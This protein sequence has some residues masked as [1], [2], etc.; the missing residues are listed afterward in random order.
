MGLPPLFPFHLAEV[1][2]RAKAKTEMGKLS[3]ET[4]GGHKS[5]KCHPGGMGVGV[6]NKSQIC[7]LGLPAPP[8]SKA[9]PHHAS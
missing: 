8:S 6:I 5:S 7:P 9:P 3:G 2:F 1:T 4:G